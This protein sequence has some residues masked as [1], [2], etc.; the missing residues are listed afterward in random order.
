MNKPIVLYDNTCNFC[1]YWLAKISQWDKQ[2]TLTKIGL[3]T[4]EASEIVLAYDVDTS[5]DSIVFVMHGRV[6]YRSQAL[7]HI[8]KTINRWAFLQLLIR[9][10]PTNF[11]DAMYDFMAR[12]RSLFGKQNPKC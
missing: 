4:D 11:A 7:L 1:N 5:I 9:I 6:Y 2:Q 12:N 3:H 10:V 8:L